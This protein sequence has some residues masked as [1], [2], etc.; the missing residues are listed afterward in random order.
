[1]VNIQIR[2]NLIDIEMISIS[3]YNF[4]NFSTGE[5]SNDQIKDFLINSPDCKT[6]YKSTLPIIEQN[7]ELQVTSF[8]ND[9]YY[10]DGY[11]FL[12]SNLN[13]IS[14]KDVTL[15]ISLGVERK[16]YIIILLKYGYGAAFETELM[17][18]DY[19]N[20]ESNEVQNSSTKLFG[21]A[22]R[23]ITSMKLNHL[24]LEDLKRSKYDIV[25]EQ[26]M[27]FEK[28]SNSGEIN[29]SDSLENQGDIVLVSGDNL[30]GKK[31]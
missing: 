4:D 20:F 6:I 19:Q 29:L 14:S 30:S 15:K 16:K 7:S 8:E 5:F 1:M 2:G 9:N 28:N 17:D 11:T 13:D 31:N 10:D 3:K 27:F 21:G 12:R 22:N 23:V 25:S 18:L 26:I 24:P